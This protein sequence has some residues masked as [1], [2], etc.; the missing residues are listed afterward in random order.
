[1]RIGLCGLFESPWGGGE[2]HVALLSSALVK[3]G[4][5]VY[6]FNAFTKHPNAQNSS[7]L[8]KTIFKF[9]R[10]SLVEDSFYDSEIIYHALQIHRF[11][12]KKKIDLLH[13]HYLNFI[14]SSWF[15]RQ[16]DKIPVVV[17]LHWCPMDYPPELASKLWHSRIFPAHQF[18]SFAFG[19]KNASRVISPSKYYSDLVERRCGVRSTVIPN[20]ICLEK[21]Q[22]LPQRETARK[23]LFLNSEDFLVLCVG[24][25]DTE[26]G[27]EYLIQAFQSVVSENP[28]ARLVIV[29]SGPLKDCLIDIVNR[30]RLTNVVF[31]G[32]VTDEY[33][34]LLLSAADLYIS[35][36]LYENLSVSILDALASGLPIICTNVGGSPEIVEDNVNGLLIPSR[37]H[38]ALSEAILKM[39]SNESMCTKFRE[40][41]RAKAQLYSEGVI[42][43]KITE[44]YDELL[45]LK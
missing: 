11:A 40:N 3:S 22:E 30:I 36:S 35:P 32:H 10:K 20:P 24:R 16:V 31:A 43:P 39:I 38:A 18:L 5:E 2:T 25:L 23:A 45:S 6:N 7:G 42:L 26:K 13:F 34:N 19:I 27:L 21:F 15:F 4:Y 37:N 28:Y 1:M 9:S 14:P 29:G 41:N 8:L 17:T 12:M 33:L 44:I